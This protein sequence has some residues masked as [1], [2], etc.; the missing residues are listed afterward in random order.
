MDSR[1]KGELEALR[2][3]QDYLTYKSQRDEPLIW[4][5]I[6]EAHEFLPK[7]GST[8]A[9]DALVQLLH[10]GRQPGISLVLAT[11]QPGQIHKD[12]MTQSDIVISHRLTAKPDVESLNLIMQSYILEGIKKQMDSLP[13]AKGSA[14]VLD[15]NSERI[16]PI[17]VRPRFTWHGG[18]SPAAIKAETKI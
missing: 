5:F 6:D 11:Q 2:R 15:D 14:I 10:E 4:L 8:P 1:K 13:S 9:T 18:E 12:V 17:K 16:Y 7:E 3:G